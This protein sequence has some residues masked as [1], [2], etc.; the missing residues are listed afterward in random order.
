[1][2]A[3]EVRSIIERHSHTDLS[4]NVRRSLEE[5]AAHHER[6]VFRT[7][8]SLLQ[9]AD[10]ELLN[11][12]LESPDTGEYFARPVAPQVA[13]LKQ[14]RQEPLIATLVDQGLF[15]AVSGD[16]PESADHSVIVQEDGTIQPVHAVPSLHLSGRLSRLAEERDDGAWALTPA[17]VRRAGGNR[18][19]VLE[20]LEELEK[21]N[22]GQMPPQLVEQVKAWGGY[23]GQAAAETLTLIEFDD[24]VALDELQARPDLA[25]YLVPFPAQGRALAVV[26]A[27]KLEELQGLL[28]QLGVQVED[29]L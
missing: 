8:V 27:G 10:P 15:P 19:K 21:L 29:G 2:D 7:G 5:W 17:S 18:T 25:P 14:D 6:I 26:P 23:Y 3:A 9:A 20:L 24:P 4:Q 16:R 28:A 13:L 11:A 12:L 22:R 1:M